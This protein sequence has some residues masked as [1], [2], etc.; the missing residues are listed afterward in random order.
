MQI[1]QAA[2]Q[3]IFFIGFKITASSHHQAQMPNGWKEIDLC[4]PWFV[5]VARCPDARIAVA[6]P[7]RN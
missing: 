2:I 1:K 3:N 5:S 6:I 4:P 7:P